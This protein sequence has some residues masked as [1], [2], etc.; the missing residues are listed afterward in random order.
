MTPIDK[1]QALADRYDQAWERAINEAVAGERWG[2]TEDE[3]TGYCNG[4]LARADV[5]R[6]C[7]AILTG[8][9]G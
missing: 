2:M 1:L 3:H 6:E 7:I 4:F 9:E 5:V 8:G